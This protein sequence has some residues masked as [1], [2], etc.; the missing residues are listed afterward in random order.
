MTRTLSG[1]R[2][3]TL[4]RATSGR[5]LNQSVS[6]VGAAATVPSMAGS[7]FTRVAWKAQAA[8]ATRSE[9]ISA[10]TR[11]RRNVRSMVRDPEED[12]GNLHALPFQQ[13]RDLRVPLLLRHRS[14]GAAVVVHRLGVGSVI[15]ERTHQRE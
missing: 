10:G 5:S 14:G 4:E 1:P 2:S 8:E 11:A 15:E 12:P 13:L 6:V 3:R 7:A 9:A